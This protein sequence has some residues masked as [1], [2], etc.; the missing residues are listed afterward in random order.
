MWVSRTGR[1]WALLRADDTAVEAVRV[2]LGVGP[3]VARVLAAR[4]YDAA[5]A[6]GFLAPGPGAFVDPGRL[7]GIDRALARLGDA[8]VRGEHV[9]LVTDYD[10]DGTTSCLILHAALDRLVQR[11]GGGATVSYHIPDRF[12]EGYGL[13][14]RAVDHAARDGVRVLVTADIGVRDHVNVRRAAEAGIDVLVVDHHLPAGESVPDAALAVL[15]PPQV[16]CAYPNKALAACGVSLKLATALLDGDP[17]R[18]ALLRSMLKLA[19]VGTVADVVDLATPENRAIVALG[20]DALNDGPHGPGLAALIEV[21]GLAGKAVDAAALGWRIGPRINAAGRLDD[22]AA[23][24]RLLRERDPDAA[25][26]Q[27]R[28]LDALNRE[29]QGIQEAL[30]ALALAQVPDPAPPFVVCAGPEDDGWHRGVVGIV[31]GK[32]RE[33]V[34]RPVAVVSILGAHATGSVRSVPA[35]HAVRA[36]DAASDLLVRYGGHAAAAGFTVATDRIDALRERLADYVAAHVDD[37]ALVPREEI[38][39]EL[40]AR[41]V[42][43]PL[44]ADLARLE[45]CGK[46]NPA[47]RIAVRGRL[48]GARVVKDRHLFFRV[49]EADAVWWNGAEHRALI[50][51]EAR[52]FGT[53]ATESWNGRDSVRVIVDDVG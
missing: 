14:Q 40:A 7:L 6:R 50:D 16:G 19:A 34:H 46:G 22:A 12:T 43:F 10:V 45:P 5:S 9:R 8:A 33:R 4:G 36:L 27:A 23:V 41:D 37:G 53:V 42:G 18:D 32:V 51:G 48:A 17:R 3:A 28:A 49:G 20:L 47:A 21:A 38:D 1:E 13:S 52:V 29:R 25:M 24:V 44:V 11:R 31:A 39:V 26:A 35:V 30:V 15:C 2:A